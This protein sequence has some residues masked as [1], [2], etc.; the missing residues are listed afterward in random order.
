M[1][2]RETECGKNVGAIDILQREELNRESVKKIG[3]N[4]TEKM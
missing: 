4:E 1:K 2:R 3:E